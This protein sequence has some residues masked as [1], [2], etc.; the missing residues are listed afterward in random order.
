MK[1]RRLTLIIAAGVVFTL[2]IVGSVIT[3]SAGPNEVA[4]DTTGETAGQATPPAG[5]ASASKPK[6][7][8]TPGAKTQTDAKPGPAEP[9]PPPAVV[10]VD[11]RDISV[12][13]GP[14]ILLNPSTVRQGS[15]VGVTGSGFDAG[16]TIDLVLKRQETDGGD[17]V[18]FFQVDK[19]GTFGGVNFTVPDGLSTGPFLVEARERKGDGQGF[20]K[21]ASVSGTVAGAAAQVKLGTQVGQPGTVVELSAKGFAPDEKV[22]AYWN[23]LGD[24]SVETLQSDARGN[25]DRASIRVPFGAVGN[26]SF[27]FV[28][29]K[30]QSP[31][32]V[33][34]LMLSLFPTV[35]LSSYAIKADNPLTFAGKDFGPGERVLVYL[36]NPNGQPILS[37]QAG[38]DG[39]FPGSSGF[40]IPFALRGQQTLIFIGEQSKAP[41]TASFDILPYTPNVQPSTYGGRPGTT[42]TFYGFGFARTEVVYVYVNRTKDSAGR[43][44]SCFAT[45]NQGNAGA[46]GQYLIPGSAPAGQLQFTL[47]G[48]KSQA[49]TTAAVEVM[50]SEVP[51]QVPEQQGFTCP[52]DNTEPGQPSQ[53]IGP[54]QQ[55][56]PAPPKP[57]QQGQPAPQAPPAKTAP[58]QPSQP[59]QQAQPAQPPQQTQPSQQTPPSQQAQPAQPPQQTP[60]AQ[61][62]QQPQPSPQP[63]Q[64]QPV[65][66]TQPAQ[67]TPQAQQ[68]QPTPQAQPAKTEQA[69]PPTPTTIPG[70]AAAP[71]APVKYTVA[72]GDTLWDISQRH[73]TSVQSIADANKIANPN[74]IHAGQELIIPPAPKPAQSAPQGAR[75]IERVIA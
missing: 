23:S 60:A 8:S 56:T 46:G 4:V 37:A 6:T 10:Q 29:D 3:R 44:V 66:Q 67:P 62:A 14:I 63:Q 36:N 65:Q 15:T 28:G 74:L 35:E 1:N 20:S 39:T 71:S 19:G 12:E 69:P 73:G 25:I 64:T 24:L 75:L 43:L 57:D 38:P 55:T 53:Q 45:D 72:P 58:T 11:G 59:P 27:I 18:T 32:T 48:T 33:N 50:A 31:V 41:T 30:S 16:A 68:T 47:V 54:P 9:T 42:V 34:F 2:I 51:V 21:V 26:N 49:S 70:P 17:V 7:P 52:L 22:Q 40:I 13:R 5:S 61:P